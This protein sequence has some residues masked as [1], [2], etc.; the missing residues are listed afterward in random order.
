MIDIND[1]NANAINMPNP[2]DSISANDITKQLTSHVS[3]DVTHVTA[4]VTTN[5]TANQITYF[6]QS[7]L[8]WFTEHGRHDLP[9]QQHKTSKPDPYP[10]WISEVMLQ[11]TQ[12]K[13]VIPYFLRFMQSFPNVDKLADADWD[14]VADHWAGLGYYARARNLH[15]AAKQL[16]EIIQQTGDYPQTVTQWETISGVGRSTAGAIVAMGLHHYGVIC[17]G[18]VKRVL[19][20]WAGMH[21]DIAKAATTKKLWRLAESLT[22]K[23]TSGNFAQAMMDMGATICT[24]KPMCLTQQDICPIQHSCIAY[25]NNTQLQLP[26]KTRKKTKP[27]K[28]SHALFMHHKQKVLWIQRPNQGIWGGL[29]SVPLFFIKKTSGKKTIL[30]MPAMSQNLSTDL[31]IDTNTNPINDT[32][33]TT[34]IDANGNLT[35]P[36]NLTSD[37]QACQKEYTTA[38]LAIKQ[39]LENKQGLQSLSNKKAKGKTLKHTLT[40]FHWLLTPYEIDLDD[41]LVET[42]NSLLKKSCVN[43][44]WLSKSEALQN[45]ALPR[46]MVKLIE[47]EMLN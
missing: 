23:Q 14:T 21:D 16:V 2:N 7:I 29:W 45:T 39:L 46:A 6:Q 11:Q 43:H 37:Q 3:T 38:E 42:I 44:Q 13:T 10:V 19:T 34:E 27:S 18:N 1:K 4:N 30:S 33:I 47:Q 24:R 35:A 31:I 26:V 8:D 12:V 20:R 5:V 9:W 36:L 28:H 15:K 25:A 40:H 22:P 41:A 17:D 32:S